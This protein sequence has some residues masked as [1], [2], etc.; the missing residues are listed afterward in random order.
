MN[1]LNSIERLAL[2]PELKKSHVRSLATRAWVA[3][4]ITFHEFED[5]KRILEDSDQSAEDALDDL[6]STALAK[7]EAKTVSGLAT[8]AEVEAM[9]QALTAHPDL[10]AT[11]D[12]AAGTVSVK[13]RETGEAVF[14]A[15]E[16]GKPPAPYIVTMTRG[17]LTQYD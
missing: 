2:N 11:K 1:L 6:R 5:V 15:I 10:T 7:M 16:K 12:S 8:A 17:L 14:R 9:T 3:E 13:V 4:I